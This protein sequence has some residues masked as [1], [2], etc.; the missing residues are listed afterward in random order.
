MAL[1]A[2]S[3]NS[4][5]R[6]VFRCVPRRPELPAVVE[7]AWKSTRLTCVVHET[8]GKRTR[9]ETISRH[10]FLAL[11]RLCRPLP[12]ARHPRIFEYDFDVS[13]KFIAH[14]ICYIYVMHA[15]NF[16]YM[17]GINIFFSGISCEFFSIILLR[18][19]YNALLMSSRGLSTTYRCGFVTSIILRALIN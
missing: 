17:N 15:R 7:F 1:A 5:A 3:R 2:A 19:D 4:N 13:W 12:V 16:F 14:Y 9:K 6:Y 18:R 11:T 10:R 8:E